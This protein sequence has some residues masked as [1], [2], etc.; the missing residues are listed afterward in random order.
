MTLP[1]PTTRS[2]PSAQIQSVLHGLE[3]ALES[4]D[5]ERVLALFT[6]D[7]YWR[8]VLAFTWNIITFE[9]HGP[10]RAMLDDRLGK[11]S[12]TG[13]RVED[14]EH[15]LLRDGVVEGFIGFTTAVGPGS[16]HIRVRD[17]NIWT[18]L[19]TLEGLDGFEDIDGTSP[20]RGLRVRRDVGKPTWAEERQNE[21]RGI[22]TTSQPY[23]LI[24]GGGHAG[25][26]LAARLRQLRVPA[27]V[28][29][30]NRRP[31]DNWRKRYKTLQ[32]HNPIWENPLPYLPYPSNWPVYMSKDKFADWLEAYTN[33]M[34]LNYWGSSHAERA[35]FDEE[36]KTWRVDIRTPSG[37]KYV[38]PKQLVMATG[39]QGI[40][41]LPSFD[42]SETFSGIQEH[43]SE[44]IGPDAYADKK[45]VVIG[46]GTSAHDIC[47]GLAGAGA[48]TTMVQ[49]STTY[50]VRPELFNEHILG[51]LYSAEAVS[52]GIT[53]EKGDLLATSVPFGLFFAFQ[54][55][56][57]DRI[58]ELDANFYEKLEAAGYLLD[59]G[60]CGSGL[61]GKAVVG[62]NNYYIEVGAAE[63]I[64]EGAIKLASGSGVDHLTEHSVVL[65]DGRE[66]PADV[67]IYATGFESMTGTIA[68]L[69]SDDVADRL[70]PVGGIGSGLPKDPGPWHGEL[71][72]MWKPVSQEALWFHGSLIAKARS[73]SRYLAL[74]LKAR[75][76]GI[77][78]P[79]YE[80]RKANP[81]K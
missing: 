75:Y 30:G 46:S 51:P 32:L 71:R 25:I 33:L 70:G 73:F 36:T 19:T 4:Q 10:L 9:G 60:P 27:L 79:T 5:R 49:R 40:P 72:N 61:F 24:I 6:D 63:M 45:V 55:S 23:V 37:M 77:P 34:E 50:I 28:I 16:G 81:P 31:G 22:G 12:P 13:W 76:E 15:A 39:M 38:Y 17:G 64:M 43:S 58:K 44:H 7:C 11:I 52:R 3:A 66:L 56:G 41:H 8:D 48:D 57:V 21:V 1:N 47:A 29:D 18:L 26:I 68:S 35:A 65:E 74:Q 42:G 54:K 14:D 80:L 69:I 59:Y 20:E 53:A 2:G 67:I 62:T 78:T